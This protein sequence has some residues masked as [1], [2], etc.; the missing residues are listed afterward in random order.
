MHDFRWSVRRAA[1]GAKSAALI[2]SPFTN[3][4]Y[5]IAFHTDCT[6]FAGLVS[7]FLGLHADHF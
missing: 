5:V 6:G 4:I 7:S 3:S 1:T 2:L